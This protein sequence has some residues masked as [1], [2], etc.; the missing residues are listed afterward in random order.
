MSSE[1]RN[2]YC[3]I[4]SSTISNMKETDWLYLSFQRMLMRILV[5]K[6]LIQLSDC[7]SYESKE[8]PSWP[9]DPSSML[10]INVD[11]LI[12]CTVHL[13]FQRFSPIRTT[14]F[15]KMFPD[16]LQIAQLYLRYTIHQ[17]FKH[18]LMNNK[19]PIK[20]QFQP[21]GISLD[22]TVIA[23]IYFCIAPYAYHNSRISHFASLHS[24]VHCTRC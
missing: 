19:Q 17:P 18:A 21:V 24:C 20:S 23:A 4:I 3:V 2:Y 1:L 22:P 15:N 14:V 9:F 7:I 13:N 12:S 5:K 6:P 10:C 8:F 16:L 11:Q